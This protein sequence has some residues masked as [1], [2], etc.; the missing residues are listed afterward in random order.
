MKLLLAIG[1]LA[2]ATPALADPCT[3]KVTGYKAGQSFSGQ[4]QAVL[5]ADSICIGSSGNRATWIEVRLADFN[6]V[7]L[8]EPGGRQ[9]KAKTASVALHRKATCTVQ[10]GRNGRTSSYDRVIASCKV[11]GK[12]LADL[13]R[14]AK[15]SEGGR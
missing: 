3:A 2:L 5:D 11:E 13:L 15:V 6:G 1:F 14:A 4:V 7:E 10:R 12:P 9:A 8:N